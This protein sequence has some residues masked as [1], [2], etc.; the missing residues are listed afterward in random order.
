[1]T[2]QH[3]VWLWTEL[4]SRA[5]LA[6]LSWLL[7]S[8]SIIHVLLLLLLPLLLHL[9]LHLHLLPLSTLHHLH[10]LLLL[11]LQPFLWA[12][13]PSAPLYSFAVIHTHKHVH[14]HVH[15]HVHIHIHVGRYRIKYFIAVC[16]LCVL[17]IHERINS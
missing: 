10:H 8:S 13:V 2:L 16:V 14:K 1:M 5:H 12:L 17:R 15:V 7:D 3:R 11:H 6:I 9:H 4:G